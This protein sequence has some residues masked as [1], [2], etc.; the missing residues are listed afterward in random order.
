MMR[1]KICVSL[2]NDGTH[3]FDGSMVTITA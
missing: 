2:D 1:Y 3:S